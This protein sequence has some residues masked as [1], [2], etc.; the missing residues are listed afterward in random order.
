MVTN[1]IE[2]PPRGAEQSLRDKESEEVEAMDQDRKASAA[3]PA[4]RRDDNRKEEGAT[5]QGCYSLKAFNVY[6]DV[7]KIPPI[8]SFLN[9]S[10]LPSLCIFMHLSIFRGFLGTAFPQRG[11]FKGL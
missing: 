3:R 8:R 4:R 9:I 11:R 10:G 1:E 7:F 2:Y 5:F 6:L